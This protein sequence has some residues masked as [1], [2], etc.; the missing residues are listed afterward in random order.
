MATPA[1]S[2]P[3]MPTVTQDWAIVS[4]RCPSKGTNGI[5]TNTGKVAPLPH[6][7]MTWTGWKP[8]PF[9]HE[10]IAPTEAKI[11]ALTIVTP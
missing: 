3:A 1:P 6:C 8:Q 11:T 7:M 2:K 9:H 5:N 4:I 10:T